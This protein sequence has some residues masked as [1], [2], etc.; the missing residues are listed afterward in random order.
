MPSIRPALLELWKTEGFDIAGDDLV[1]QRIALVAD[2]VAVHLAEIMNAVGRN[3]LSQYQDVLQWSDQFDTWVET[4]NAA[5][6]TFPNPNALASGPLMLPSF[7]LT[8]EELRH[9]FQLGSMHLI[10]LIFY[11]DIAARRGLFHILVARALSVDRPISGEADRLKTSFVA[12]LPR[13]RDRVASGDATAQE[14]IKVIEWAL[15]PVDASPQSSPL[16]ISSIE[17]ASLRFA[18]C[19]LILD[20]EL[21]DLFGE[22]ALGASVA[23]RE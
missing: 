23:V 3:V 12:Q 13:L 22:D 21:S 14:Y 9:A 6:W 17:I 4:S 10:S 11:D 20:P 18:R 2:A 15:V 8:A 19:M 7:R 1:Q 16:A 5:S